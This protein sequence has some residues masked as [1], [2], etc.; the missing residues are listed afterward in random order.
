MSYAFEND[1]SLSIACGYFTPLAATNAR[2]IGASSVSST[3]RNTTFGAASAAYDEMRSGVSPR[4]GGHQVAHTLRTSVLPLYVSSVTVRPSMVFSVNAG[5]G[6]PTC[7]P[8]RTAGA[9]AGA[10]ASGAA[11]AALAAAEAARRARAAKTG[12]IVRM[13]RRYATGAR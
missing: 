10:P 8:V 3:P 5:A 7:G 13:P 6:W 12:A 4:H 11:G 2:T 9:A 1:L